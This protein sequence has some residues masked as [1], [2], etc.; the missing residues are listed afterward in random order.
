[1]KLAPTSKKIDHLGEVHQREWDVLVTDQQLWRQSM[2]GVM[3]AVMEHICVV[4]V[5]SP[6][7]RGGQ[8]AI[9]IRSEWSGAI[10]VSDNHVSQE[11]K[12]ILELPERISTLVHEQLEPSFK[13]RARHQYFTANM[14][15]P[16][17]YPSAQ[18][19]GIIEPFIT[20]GA[21][22]VLAG[23]YKRSLTS[24]AWLL[25]S[26]TPDVAP[27]VRAALAEWHSLAPDRF[28]GVPDWSEQLEWMT[29]EERDIATKVKDIQ[30]RREALLAELDATEK[31]LI[32]ELSDAQQRAS[33][34]E[35][36][37]LTSQ[38][39]P[40]VSAVMRAFRELGFLVTDADLDAAPGDHLEDLRVEDPGSPGWI[41]IAEVKGYTKGAKTEALT[42]LMRFN[43]R[44]MQRTGKAANASWYVVNQFLNRDPSTRQP[45]LH[46]KDDDV[47]AFADGGGLVIDSVTLFNLLHLVRTGEMAASDARQLLRAAVGRLEIPAN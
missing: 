4:F 34:Y 26:D 17:S 16:I 13:A 38:S 35:R 18:E 39:D 2:Q 27:W 8:L 43:L 20:T 23:R 25:P 36:A 46:G 44:Y 41:A 6:A 10:G 15:G 5:A 42:Q 22:Y 24:E 29:S 37:L 11:L 33:Q 12:R 9:E 21:G 40:L 45:V 31:D 7:Y 1:M 28:P 19:K 3:P 30:H 47:A 32:Q 14:Q